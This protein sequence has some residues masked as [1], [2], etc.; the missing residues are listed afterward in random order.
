MT[1]SRA[2]LL[3]VVLLVAGLTFSGVLRNG[4]VWDDDGFI[5]RNLAMHDLANVPRFFVSGDALGTG[6]DN[7]YYRPL[8][9]TTFALDWALWGENAAGHHATSLALHLAVCA[10]VFLV[11]ARLSL[12]IGSA[13]AAALWFAVHPANSEPVAYISARAD[14]LCAAFLLGSFLL[15]LRYLERPSPRFLGGSAAVYVLALLSKGVAVILPFVML[16]HLWSYVRRPDRVRVVLPYVGLT[17]AFLGLRTLVLHMDSWDPVPWITRLATTMVTLASY[18]RYTVLPI[19]LKVA[20]DT[21]PATSVLEPRVLLSAAVLVAIAVPVFL[22]ILRK[23]RWPLGVVWFVLALLPVSGLLTLLV[24][25]LMADRYLYVPISGASL[26]LAAG[27]DRLPE[28]AFGWRFPRLPRVALAGC[29]LGLALV[30]AGRIPAWHDPVTLGELATAQA[31]ERLWILDNLGAAYG[32]AG[33]LD[34]AERTFLRMGELEK[35]FFDSPSPRLLMRFAM[36]ALDRGDLLRA[37]H[38]VRA[39][40]AQVPD[41]WKA[42][43]VLGI[44]RLRQGDP[45]GAKVALLHSLELHPFNRRAMQLLQ[46][47]RDGPAAAAGG[48]EGG[49]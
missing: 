17:F 11:A 4:F 38:G 40:L 6:G 43:E 5:V 33:D 7:P 28:P 31:P 44:I 25:T 46:L 1:R 41:D 30:T 26:A 9:T 29:V 10:L 14:L 19:G 47:A 2:A 36:V 39:A 45:E 3:A 27:L 35:R 24:P 13:F 48:D 15:Y 37:E 21:E 8:T 12:R 20:Y 23:R 22:A 18:I 16:V 49:S 34:A 32:R 42:Y